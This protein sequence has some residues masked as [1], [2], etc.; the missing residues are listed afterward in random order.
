M[1]LEQNGIASWDELSGLRVLNDLTHLIVNKNHI[2]E[3]YYK[4]GFRGLKSLSF[5][6][7][8]ISDWTTFDALNEFDSRITEVRAA[9]NPVIGKGKIQVGTDANPIDLSKEG[10]NDELNKAKCIAVSRMEFLK[11]YNGTKVTENE[12]KD[13]ELFYMKH[14]L[15]T[16]LTEVIV[17]EKEEDR[18]L[19]DV[20]NKEFQDYVNKFHPRFYQLIQIYGNPLEMISLKKEAKNIAQSSAKCEFISETQATAGK[21]MTKKVLLNMSISNLKALCSKLFKVNVI[22]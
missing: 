4:P 10:G 11:K 15:E 7:N 9:G 21:I 3:I 17:V 8:L 22:D 19:T 13:V 2:K 20:D 16:Y 5:E 14:A 12:R 6:D 1:N 18:V